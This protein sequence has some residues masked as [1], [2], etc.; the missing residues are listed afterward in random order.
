LS[1]FRYEDMGLDSPVAVVGFPGTGLAGAMAASYLVGQLKMRPV[2]GLAGPFMPPYCS[3]FEGTALP[4]VRMYGRKATVEGGKDLIVCCSEYAPEPS[5]CYDVSMAMLEVLKE[6]GCTTVLCLEGV[7]KQVS[8]KMMECRSGEG[9]EEVAKRLR[10]PELSTGMLRGPTAV[11]MYAGPS[12]GINVLAVVNPADPES[13]DPE[14]AAAF[15]TP[16]RRAVT[17]L[18]VTSKGLLKQAEEFHAQQ[19]QAQAQAEAPR[20]SEDTSLYV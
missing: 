17:G 5:N 7:P 9:S 10:L 15:L 2:A 20:P 11:M 14:A 19:A 1:I 4:P 8:F 3:L 12:M 13:P 18:R 6:M 16:I